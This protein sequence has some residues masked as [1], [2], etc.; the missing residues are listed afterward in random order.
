MTTLI[1]LEHTHKSDQMLLNSQLLRW[2]L[3][4]DMSQV[5]FEAAIIYA[6]NYRL[7]CKIRVML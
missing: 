3:P 7:R 2:Q 4:F 6:V 5:V 1:I